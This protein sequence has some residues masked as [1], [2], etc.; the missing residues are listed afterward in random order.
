MN[1][2]FN[3]KVV[4]IVGG[5]SGIGETTAIEFAK[6]GAKIVVAGRRSVEG[7][8][9]V[10]KIKTMQGEAVFI[11]ADV[12]DADSVESLIDGVVNVYG[13]IDCAFNNAGIT[14]SIGNIHD[15]AIDDWANV[16]NINLNGMFYCL[17]FQITQMLKQGN[18]V[19]V[20]NSSIA[21]L[22][23]SQSYPFPAYTSSKHGLIG[24]T[25]AAALEYARQGIRINAICPGTIK[26][27]LTKDI[28][29]KSIN[30]LIPIGRPGISE[31]IAPAVLWLCSDEASFVTG[32]VM[33]LDGGVT[34]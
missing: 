12:T 1:N 14:G 28:I 23:A 5:T 17:K 9:V 32:S 26:T 25:K 3:N 2:R 31:E 20:N 34:T 11:K 30:S 13:R 29:S 4:L 33:T 7:Q 8:N 16:M 6:E 27:P 19:I 24:L 18:G 21:G 15:L 22:S 10:E